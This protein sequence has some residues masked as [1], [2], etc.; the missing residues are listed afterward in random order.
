MKYAIAIFDAQELLGRDVAPLIVQKY[1]DSNP[2]KALDAICAIRM[3][4]DDCCR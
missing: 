4:F 3:P 2:F 1:P